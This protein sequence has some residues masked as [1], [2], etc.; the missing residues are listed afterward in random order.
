MSEP[1]SMFAIYNNP[2][3]F[4]DKFVVR[5]WLI[6]PGVKTPLQKPIAI[7]DSLEEAR[8]AVPASADF[9]LDRNPDDDSVIVETWV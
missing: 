2:S 5:E 8:A 9:C 4:P 3:D 7:V 6:G 1:I